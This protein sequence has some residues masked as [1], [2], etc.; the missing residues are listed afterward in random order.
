MVTNDS[1]LIIG[2]PFGESEN[3]D[4]IAKSLTNYLAVK[5][6]MKNLEISPYLTHAIIFQETAIIPRP[7]LPPSLFMHKLLNVVNRLPR[8]WD[9]L[10]LYSSDC[11]E[12]EARDE[13]LTESE[14]FQQNA[15]VLSPKGIKV[16]LESIPLEIGWREKWRKKLK[17]FRVCP[18][19]VAI[20]N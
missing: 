20:V 8:K 12:T 14:K 9:I 10:Q 2:K 13:K 15:L 1:L 18:S 7:S 16:L 19:L 5:R 6:T 4:E 17:V 3:Y 11:L